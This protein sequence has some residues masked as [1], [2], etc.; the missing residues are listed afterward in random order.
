LLK[1]LFE[2]G[3]KNRIPLDFIKL[4]LDGS[5]YPADPDENSIGQIL[6][7]ITEVKSSDIVNEK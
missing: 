1:Q 4:H 6:K 3:G 2:N 7:L 5:Y